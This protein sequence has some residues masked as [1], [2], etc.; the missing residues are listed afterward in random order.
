MSDA[1]YT[2]GYSAYNLQD[3]LSVLKRY[4]ITAVA[5]VRSSPYS[6]YKPEFNRE[7]LAVQLKKNGIFYVFLGEE[8][9]A[10]PADQKCYS[11]GFVNFDLLAEHPL[12]QQGIT[13]LK[14]GVQKC[15]IALMCAE[16]DPTHC[17][18]LILVVHQFSKV[19]PIPVYHILPDGE[20]EAND[21]TT[22]RLLKMLHLDMEE[23]PG[24]GKTLEERIEEAFSIQAQAIAYKNE[25]S[26]EHQHE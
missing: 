10:R 7:E 3:F 23:L 25:E 5:D 15:K 16:Q 17:H 4:G 12:F 22:L 2:I 6:R 19:C 18:R 13:R 21:I 14:R 9:G 8:C 24:C 26:T 11:D 20:S 1:I